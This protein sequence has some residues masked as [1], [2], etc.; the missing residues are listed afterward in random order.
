[1]AFGA[2]AHGFRPRISPAHRLTRLPR[3]ERD[4]RLHREIELAAE[5][6]TAGRWNDADAR[7]IESHDEGDL[8]PVHVGSLGR[9]EDLDA[10]AG[11]LCIPRL[12]FHIGMLDEGRLEA[13]AGNG[14]RLGQPLRS[15]ALLEI[16][17]DE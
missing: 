4:Q 3:G 17:A 6:A 1:M 14:V 15:I 2:G 10:I 16:A 8:V 7:G 13:A 9:N 5:T 11:A 12:R